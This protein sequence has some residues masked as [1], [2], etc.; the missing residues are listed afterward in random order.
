ML[1]EQ[2]T[3][4]VLYNPPS[5]GSAG[6]NNA[7]EDYANLLNSGELTVVVPL[8]KNFAFV[9]RE[10]FKHDLMAKQSNCVDIIDVKCFNCYFRTFTSRSFTTGKIDS[11]EQNI[12]ESSMKIC[13]L[14]RYDFI[15]LTIFLIIYISIYRTK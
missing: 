5:I 9:F 12:E 7:L 14:I 1:L 6:K 4:S 15:I 2:E 13:L 11:I 10:M 8:I 3:T